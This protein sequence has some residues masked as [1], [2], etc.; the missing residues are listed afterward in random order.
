M[1]KILLFFAVV[2]AGTILA[3]AQNKWSLEDC[4]NY[5]LTNNV[6]IKQQMLNIQMGEEDVLKDKLNY[7]PDLN[8][9]ASHGYNWGQTIDPYTNQFAT[10]RVRSN[11]FY[12]SASFVIFNGLQKYNTM[13]QDQFNLL[14]SR[15]SVDKFMDDVSMSIAAG[16]LQILF[17]KE[18]LKIAQSQLDI[19]HQ[20]VE[21][22]KKLVDAGTLARGDLLIVEAQ[23]STE[24]LQVITAQNNLDIAYLT[25]AQ[26][27]DLPSAEGFEIEEPDI[28]LVDK[29]QSPLGPDEIFVFA[30]ANQPDIKSAELSLQAS[31]KTLA[32][33]RGSLSPSLN[34]SGSWGTGYSGA[35]R[36]YNAGIDPI[37]IPPSPIGFTQSGETVYSNPYE[38]F[39][40]YS[41]KS[42]NS[43]LSDNLNKSVMLHLNIPIFNGWMARSNIAK[44]K[45]GIEN[46]SY[47]LEL[48]KIRLRK[49]IQQAYADALA[50]LK[51][52]SAAEKK[53]EATT[54][55]YKYAEQKFNVG[56]INSV[57]YNQAKKDLTR[58][59]AELLQAK[60]D[61]LFK[62]VVLDFY[63]GKPITLKN[64]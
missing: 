43:Q 27:L 26:L 45:I 20:Q 22:T 58:A 36:D 47:T 15:Y 30:T 6:D 41:V 4:I 14:A 44:A 8:G 31:E 63:M 34:V 28:S 46:A 12:L 13:K 23:S 49:T 25:L 42:F 64:H 5:A 10:E 39:Q 37:T 52:H 3:N 24:E 21:R 60:Y 54:E 32:L 19:T 55:S 51:T 16:Y 1:K 61:Y 50:A 53:V 62:T 18:L 56:L 11:N 7:L 9:Y 57:D 59:Q 35:A 48:A 40:N 17:D 29:P 33:A 2:A 38:T